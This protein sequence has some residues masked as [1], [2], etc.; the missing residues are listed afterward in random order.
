MEEELSS[1]GSEDEYRNEYAYSVDEPSNST[2]SVNVAGVAV[3][4][5]ID[6]GAICNNINKKMGQSPQEKFNRPRKKW[7]D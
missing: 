3:N 7:D 5:L 6:S 1:S 4:M 2:V